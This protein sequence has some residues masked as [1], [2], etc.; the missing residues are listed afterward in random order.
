MQ[1]ILRY[2]SKE[3]LKWLLSDRGIYIAPAFAQSDKAEGVFDHTMASTILKFYG[4]LLDG[5]QWKNFDNIFFNMMDNDRKKL[6]LT[7]WYLGDNE[8][9]AMWREYAKDGVILVSNTYKLMDA[10]PRPLT[11]AAAFY[12]I[13]YDHNRKQSSIYDSLKYKSEE[14]SYENEFRLVIDLERYSILTGYE[15]EKFGRVF[16]GCVPSYQSAEITSCMGQDDIAQAHSI[17]TKKLNGYIIKIDLNKLLTEIRINPNCLEE[18]EVDIRNLCTSNGLLI[19][20]KDSH[21]KNLENKG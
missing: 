4:L 12:E 1:T 7:S 8:T 21:L 20:I 19:P 5:N 9:L 15:N 3:K 10:L 11:Y 16:V 13:I 6:H 17:I 14:F 2:L 18:E